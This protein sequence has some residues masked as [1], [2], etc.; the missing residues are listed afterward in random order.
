MK[1]P[2]LSFVLFAGLASG[3][4]AIT[5]DFDTLNGGGAT[6]PGNI[7]G[8]EFTDFGVTIG[9]TGQTTQLALFNSNC[10]P[11]FPG[12]P[13]TGGD[14]DLASGPSFGTLPQGR[15]LIGQQPGLGEPGDLPG[16]YTFSFDF[17]RVVTLSTLSLLDLDEGEFNPNNPILSFKLT[18]A[19]T[20]METTFG[21]NTAVSI[22]G[23]GNNSLAT[24]T[25][26]KSN[27]TRLEIGFNGISGAVTSL[28]YAPV[29]LP[30]ALPLL[31]AGLGALGVAARRRKA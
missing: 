25:F 29:P 10:G 26:D 18:F 30:A 16:T 7:A 27:V 13:C 1:A 23:S 8:T 21:Y 2:F 12:T 14:T 11:D 5:L 4:G 6:T 19:D 9:L 22:I 20:S 17:D 24:F 3:A 28:D 15:V 31:A